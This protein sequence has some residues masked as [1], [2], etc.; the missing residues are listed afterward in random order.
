MEER[1]QENFRIL[2]DLNGKEGP[3]QRSDDAQT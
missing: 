3:D 1:S 2:E